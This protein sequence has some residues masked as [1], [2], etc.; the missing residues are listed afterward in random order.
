MSVAEKKKILRRLTLRLFKADG[1]RTDAVIEFV[2]SRTRKTNEHDYFWVG[3]KNG[4]SLGS[5]DA[6]E[7]FAF[8]D[9]VR[10]MQEKARA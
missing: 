2:P 8:V 6:D 1:G 3:D 4:A 7:L 10:A 5:A 9:E